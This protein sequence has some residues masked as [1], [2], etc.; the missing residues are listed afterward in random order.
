LADRQN[1]RKGP[2]A[3]FDVTVHV[4]NFTADPFRKLSKIL[5]KF[6]KFAHPA[7]LLLRVPRPRRAGKWGGAGTGPAARVSKRTEGS[8]PPA[9]DGRA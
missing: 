8:P 2:V 6:S 7:I 3:I 4:V 9:A 1:R 5:T